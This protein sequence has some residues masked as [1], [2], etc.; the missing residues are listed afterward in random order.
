MLQNTT[1]PGS[2]SFVD[3]LPA[4][5]ILDIFASLGVC[6]V[7][8][9]FA[10]TLSLVCT[11][12]RSVIVKTPTFWGN[13]DVDLDD[14]RTADGLKWLHL[15]IKRSQSALI[16]GRIFGK[17]R[18]NMPGPEVYALL[19]CCERW[20]ELFL[21]LH[22]ETLLAVMSPIKGRLKNLRRLSLSVSIVPDKLRMLGIPALFKDAPVLEDISFSPLLSSDYSLLPLRQIQRCEIEDFCDTPIDELNP[23]APFLSILLHPECHLRTLCIHWY[24]DV[25]GDWDCGPLYAPYLQS[26]ELRDGTGHLDGQWSKNSMRLLNLLTAPSLEKFSAKRSSDLPISTI[27]QFLERSACRLKCID[28]RET[29]LLNQDIPRLLGT[30]SLTLTYLD[31]KIG[32]PRKLQSLLPP[33]AEYLTFLPNL[34]SLTLFVHSENQE[35]TWRE[36]YQFVEQQAL[37]EKYVDEMKTLNSIAYERCEPNLSG[38]GSLKHTRLEHFEVKST[39]FS[40]FASGYAQ[41]YA[42]RQLSECT[43]DKEVLGALREC[44]EKFSQA[45]Y[46]GDGLG[47]EDFNKSLLELLVKHRETFNKVTDVQYLYV[48]QSVLGL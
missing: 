1:H 30:S 46:F 26:L 6:S 2:S 13:I 12:F 28:L 18:S 3:K 15:K 44:S 35:T 11:T 36:L 37:D 39:T 4:E 29:T 8:D 23:K 42:L 41:L 40:W 5:I 21:S 20:E 47:P 38:S 19:M 9:S 43:L 27:L 7:D 48:R 32:D 14:E 31:I 45:S 34:K 22:P 25:P 17:K 10:Q 16:H 24:S 33:L